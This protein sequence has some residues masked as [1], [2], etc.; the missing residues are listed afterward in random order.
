MKK[1]PQK[2]VTETPDFSLICL[3][4]YSQPTPQRMD[5]TFTHTS[6]EV[7]GFLGRN[8]QGSSISISS[9]HIQPLSLLTLRSTKTCSHTSMHIAVVHEIFLL[10]TPIS[11]V[12]ETC[13]FMQENRCPPKPKLPNMPLTLSKFPFSSN[14]LS[15]LQ[16]S[17]FLLNLDKTPLLAAHHSLCL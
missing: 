17:T 15:F 1:L 6:Q 7:I 3:L 9:G 8:T 10:C 13:C 14:P 5:N 4:L 16:T 2:L 12:W 11:P